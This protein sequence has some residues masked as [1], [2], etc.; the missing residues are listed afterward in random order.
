M[1]HPGRDG[2]LLG[3]RGTYFATGAKPKA[4]VN[5]E[6]PEKPFAQ[7]RVIPLVDYWGLIKHCQEESFQPRGKHEASIKRWKYFPA[8]IQGTVRW[9][10]KNTEGLC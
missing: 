9:V 5:P 7:T 2:S 4:L 6:K 1:L 8:Y 3:P 10:Q